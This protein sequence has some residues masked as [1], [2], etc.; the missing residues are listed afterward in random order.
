MLLLHSSQEVS[1]S[2]ALSLDVIENCMLLLWHH[3][4]FFLVSCKPLD[5]KT[6]LLKRHATNQMRKL[7]GK[8]EVCE[9]EEQTAAGKGVPKMVAQAE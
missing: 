3:L 8:R 2:L 9:N 4:E 5:A 6:S 1:L 7:N